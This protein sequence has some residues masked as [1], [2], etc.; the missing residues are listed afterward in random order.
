MEH[1][2][3]RR[4]RLRDTMDFVSSESETST[5]RRARWLRVALVVLFAFALR[6]GISFR[7]HN[8]DMDSWTVTAGLALIGESPYGVT[9][10]YNYGPVW[11]AI[12][13]PLAWLHETLGLQRLLGAESFHAVI[14]AFLSL[15]DIAVA[16]LL[17][18]RAG[19]WAALLFLFNPVLILL[20]GYH[21]QIDTLA[22][23][24]GLLAWV[25]I[26][27]RTIAMSWPRLIASAALLALSLAT[28]HVL[29]LLPV[30]LVMSRAVIPDFTKRFA[31][32]GVAYA[33]FASSFVPFARTADAIGGIWT[34]VIAYE[35]VPFAGALLPKLLSFVM[36]AS[37]AAKPVPVVHLSLSKLLFVIILMLVGVVVAWKKPREMFERYLLALVIFTPAMADQYLAIPLVACAT[38]LRSWA[39]WAYCAVAL[40]ILLVSPA[41]IMGPP[42]PPLEITHDVGRGWLQYWQAQACL[43]FLLLDMRWSAARRQA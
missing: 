4:Y 39:T 20:T 31:Y 8:Y 10:R 5:A 29:I 15:V 24:F 38:A 21:S 3:R 28:K 22:V 18:R 30:W 36:S 2:C 32:A 1:R 9:S 7:G 19:R 16:W 12:L 25:L 35:G 34:Q 17:S 11:Y 43:L 26:E 40:A 6:V 41:N 33:L 13:F 37:A 23:L 27:S 42:T 14:A